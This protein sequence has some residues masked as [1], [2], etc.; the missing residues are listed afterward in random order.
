METPM[1]S[2]L[3]R[4]AVLGVFAAMPALAQTPIAP[5][6]WETTNT[7]L[8]PLHSAK[9]ERRC[10]R[11][12]DVAK[13]MEGPGNHIY[14]CTYPTKV[15]RDGRIRLKGSCKSRDGA[16]FPIEGTGTYSRESFHLEAVAHPAIG[17]ITLPVRAATD[18]HRLAEACP[19]LETPEAAGN[20]SGGNAP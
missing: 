1:P 5:G 6:W 4:L 15:F 18:A 20:E 10:I 3:A 7:V 19:K 16:P 13:F 11:P 14:H 12:A 17:P 2:K 9:T 8:S